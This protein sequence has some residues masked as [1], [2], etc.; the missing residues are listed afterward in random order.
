MKMVAYDVLSAPQTSKMASI[1]TNLSPLSAPIYQMIFL[2]FI[3]KM[4]ATNP[5]PS[6]PPAPK[7][8]HL[9]NL[10]MDSDVLLYGIYT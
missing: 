10:P 5:V 9:S 1:N 7:N 2:L 3:T 4:T 8:S 6:S